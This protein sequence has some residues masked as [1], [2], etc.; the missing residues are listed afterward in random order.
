MYDLFDMGLCFPIFLFF[1]FFFLFLSFF[2]LPRRLILVLLSPLLALGMASSPWFGAQKAAIPSGGWTV[3]ACDLNLDGVDDIVTNNFE[4]N[5][6]T[7]FLSKTA[8]DGRHGFTNQ[9]FSLSSPRHKAPL[10]LVDVK[11]GDMNGDGFPDLIYSEASDPWQVTPHA[12]EKANAVF[13]L[14]NAGMSDGTLDFNHVLYYDLQGVGPRFLAL[15]DMTG[16]GR[17]D[18]VVSMYD[19]PGV[20]IIENLP[21]LE[22]PSS[23]S[24]RAMGWDTKGCAW[25]TV[26]L[27]DF[28]SDGRMDIAMS[29]HCGIRIISKITAKDGHFTTF[30]D[31]HQRGQDRRLMGIAVAD[32]NGDGK[33]DLAV[34]TY[35]PNIWIFYNDA[36]PNGAVSFQTSPEKFLSGWQT[37]NLITCDINGDGNADLVV[38]NIGDST[39]TV[40][41]NNRNGPVVRFNSTRYAT[42][43][44]PTG[45]AVGNWNNNSFIDLVVLNS[46]EPSI[47]LFSGTSI[48]Q[49]TVP[50][51][52]LPPS[53]WI[54]LGQIS[55][56]Y[57]VVT[58]TVFVIWFC[59]RFVYQRFCDTLPRPLKTESDSTLP[60]IEDEDVELLAAEEAEPHVRSR[61]HP[62]YGTIGF[63]AP[64]VMVIYS[65]ATLGLGLFFWW[66]LEEEPSILLLIVISAASVVYLSVSLARAYSSCIVP[67]SEPEEKSSA[68]WICFILLI[69]CL[70][71]AS[72]MIIG[73]VVNIDY[74]SGRGTLVGG[75]IMAGAF[76]MALLLLVASA[77]GLVKGPLYK[78][79]LARQ[80]CLEVPDYIGSVILSE[81]LREFCLRET[82]VTLPDDVEEE[83]SHRLLARLLSERRCILAN[84]NL[85]ALSRRLNRSYMRKLIRKHTPGKCVRSLLKLSSRVPEK[86]RYYIGGFV[87]AAF[88]LIPFIV[89]GLLE[90]DSTAGLIFR[91]L[92]TG[93]QSSLFFYLAQWQASDP[94]EFFTAVHAAA[95][96]CF[97][98]GTFNLLLALNAFLNLPGIDFGSIPL[99]SLVDQLGLWLPLTL[100]PLIFLTVV[101]K[102][103]EEE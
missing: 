87:G 71:G 49:P 4:S 9:T 66:S 67:V 97:I 68:G 60:D 57:F 21:D 53:V 103:S 79:S 95:Y 30:S 12:T 6:T 8:D 77:V 35:G 76:S 16:D 63:V 59:A 75:S 55:L 86:F 22:D 100:I 34:S 42:G 46:G 36:K 52:V 7:I 2:F 91:V 24:M 43:R 82:G 13:V 94:L 38:I 54:F 56:W 5:S 25:W 74:F 99:Y 50:A 83:K 31:P 78:H 41:T 10:R 72:E 90:K 20:W 33:P 27:A 29:G 11:C 28:D 102:M 64:V 48:E 19:S 65:L 93:L 98:S 51:F 92:V 23:I 96:L 84:H 73:M 101:T 45:L 3:T 69:I 85:N 70:L 32:F 40:L 89:A 80:L 44:E 26:A 47:S 1:F 81:E 37:F 18:I 62:V 17:L 15:G 39:M 58:L 88:F 61:C 14:L